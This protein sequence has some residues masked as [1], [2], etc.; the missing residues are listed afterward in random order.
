VL[1]KFRHGAARPYDDASVRALVAGAVDGLDAAAV[2]VVGV[3]APAAPT[4]AQT[5]LVR[6]GPIAVTRGSAW[7][8]KLLLGA[9]LLVNV[10]VVLGAAIALRRRTLPPS[11]PAEA[12]DGSSVAPR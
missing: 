10:L 11:T 7:A 12:G 6:F 9:S 1:I 2:T 3:P 5:A 8:L 4:S